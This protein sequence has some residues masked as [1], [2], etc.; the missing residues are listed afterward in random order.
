MAGL[1]DDI[2]ELNR[3]TE[4]FVLQAARSRSVHVFGEKAG[5]TAVPIAFIHASDMHNHPVLWDRMVQYMN[6]YSDYFR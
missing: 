1:T 3:D 6:H 4:P 2:I 5:D